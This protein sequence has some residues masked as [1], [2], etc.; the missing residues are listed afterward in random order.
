MNMER[1]AKATTIKG[2]ARIITNSYKRGFEVAIMKDDEG[3][4]LLGFARMSFP[5]SNKDKCI[6]RIHN[7][8]SYEAILMSLRWR[9][10][11]NEIDPKSI[12]G[13]YRIF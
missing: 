1:K 9:I 11:N 12:I 13:Q 10:E 5:S 7:V 2:L 8:D 4:Y 3:L 6:V